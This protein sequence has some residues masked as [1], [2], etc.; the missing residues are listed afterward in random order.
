MYN[1]IYSR[2]IKLSN[3]ELNRI[4]ERI[5][6]IAQE[7]YD[8]EIWDSLVTDDDKFWYTDKP[9][10]E[11]DF[12]VV[13]VLVNY[14]NAIFQDSFPEIAYTDNSGKA[15]I[16]IFFLFFIYMYVKSMK[17]MQS[18][19]TYLPPELL[20]DSIEIVIDHLVILK[21]KHLNFSSLSVDLLIDILRLNND[22]NQEKRLPGLY[23]KPAIYK[24]WDK[25][26]DETVV[27]VIMLDGDKFKLVNDNCGH[28]VGD[29]VLEIYR[30][31]ILSA[32]NLSSK[33]KTRAFP[34]RWGGEEFCVCIFDSNEEEVISLSKKIKSEL[35]IHEKWEE[36]KKRKQI[37][38]VR[39]PRT[40]SQGV[41]LGKKSDFPYFN[42]ILGEADKQMYKAKKRGHRDCIFYCD[43]KVK[44]VDNFQVIRTR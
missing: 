27:G 42:A 12:P 15:T 40:F 10:K 14:G 26:S 30:D 7:I 20:K 22:L 3:D 16:E 2:E 4:F 23:N 44:F 18:I 9:N 17:S 1:E 43:R 13:P 21:K 6:T 8:P 5:H 35:H 31:S 29:E 41:A 19:T 39:F 37:K 28:G 24:I 33:L 38:K 34:A 32:I 25:K 36:L 11:A